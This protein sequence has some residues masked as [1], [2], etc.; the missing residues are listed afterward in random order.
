VRLSPEERFALTLWFGRV[1]DL[2][3]AAHD[4]LGRGGRFDWAYG[5]GVD[6]PWVVAEYAAGATPH[7]VARLLLNADPD[8]VLWDD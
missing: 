5:P 4:S 6:D 7:E 3:D 1:V 2:V 8:E